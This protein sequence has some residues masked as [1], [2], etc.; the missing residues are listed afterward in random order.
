MRPLH[1]C[2][3]LDLMLPSGP[4]LRGKV[5][6]A[7]GLATTAQ[8]LAFLAA[9]LGLFSAAWY[10]TVIAGGLAL[11]F[12]IVSLIRL[13]RENLVKQHL[14]DQISAS[15]DLDRVLREAA[16]SLGLGGPPRGW[17]VSLYRLRFSNGRADT[18]I[19]QLEARVANQQ[20]YELAND[21]T[22]MSLTQGV[23]RTAIG[24]ADQPRGGIDELPP[25]PDPETESDLWFGIMS[26]WGFEREELTGGIKARSCC[27]R[28]FR[29]G[30]SRGGGQ[31]MTL[32]LVAESERPEGITRQR[33]EE[34]LTRPVFELL[35]ELI[36]LREEVRASLTRHA[37]LPA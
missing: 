16:I 22:Q 23:L 30:L 29:V 26:A 25:L 19:W 36:H 2:K 8:V 17:R 28:V 20:A 35:Y 37:E 4:R 14:A 31:D 15:I 32:G 21:L 10:F 11:L 34:V 1:R 12:Y 33:M 24:A 18:G 13:R 5:L 6:S 7:H 27:G 9:F 3:R